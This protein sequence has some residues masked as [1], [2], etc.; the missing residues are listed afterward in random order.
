[1]P[2]SPAELNGLTS[3]DVERACGSGAGKCP[4]VEH[5]KRAIILRLKA[6]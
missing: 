2:V 1:M 6:D 4:D 5:V 3:V